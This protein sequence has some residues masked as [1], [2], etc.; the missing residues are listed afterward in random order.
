MADTTERKAFDP[1]Q[2]FVQPQPTTPME[3]RA[4]I[5]YARMISYLPALKGHIRVEARR[6]PTLI[7]EA[8]QLGTGVLVRWGVTATQ[9]VKE[10]HQI[11]RA[12]LAAY[13]ILKEQTNGTRIQA[14]I[15][16]ETTDA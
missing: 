5:V 8:H 14:V 7:F 16:E 2:R 9:G 1:T 13:Q 12:S 15:R 6:D 3:M 11:Q 10:T 4:A